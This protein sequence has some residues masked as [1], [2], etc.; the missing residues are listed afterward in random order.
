MQ[1]YNETTF[2][3]CY[4]SR[5]KIAASRRRFLSPDLISFSVDLPINFEDKVAV[6]IDGGLELYWDRTVIM[7]PAQREAIT[8]LEEKLREGFDVD[9]VRYDRPDPLKRA[10]LAASLIPQA[11]QRGD[12]SLAATALALTCTSLPDL[13]QI[14]YR[15]RQGDSWD[16]AF[17]S[18]RCYA[19]DERP[20][21][22]M[23]RTP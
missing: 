20:I 14:Q 19:P 11:L 21:Q 7:T 13:K 23:S 22:L 6:L 5:F 3:F 17:V 9:G 8:R 1:D 10:Q 15:R 2:F 4:M 18:D 12:D 16:I